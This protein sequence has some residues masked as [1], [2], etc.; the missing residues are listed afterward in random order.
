MILHFIPVLGTDGASHRVKFDTSSLKGLANATD[1]FANGSVVFST[2]CVDA[3][4]ARTNVV[5]VDRN[6]YGS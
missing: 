3:V 6:R 5:F 1:L 4:D 2:C